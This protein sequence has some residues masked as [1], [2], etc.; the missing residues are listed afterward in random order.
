MKL[1]QLNVWMGRLTRQILPLIE[2]EQPDI[3]TLQEVFSSSKPIVFPDSTFDIFERIG[4]ALAYEHAYFSPVCTTTVDGQPVGFGNAIYSKYPLEDR[5]TIFTNGVYC[6]NASDPSFDTNTRNAQLVTVRAGD[7]AF[8]LVNHHAYWEP[9]PNG[10][11]ASVDAMRILADAIGQLSGPVLFAGDLN[12]NPGTPTLQ[13][14][15]GWLE[16]LTATYQVAD[17]LSCLGKVHGVACDHIF[18]SPEV[19]VRSFSVLDD[20]VSDHKSLLLE[21]DIAP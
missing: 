10:S 5:Q 6:P 15:S 16:D 12:V 13:L 7:A 20:I 21:F 9:T 19:Q 17:T 14:F 3:I 11:G 4:S 18:V 2:R 1:L 8:N